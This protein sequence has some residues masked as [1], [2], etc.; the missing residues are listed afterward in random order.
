MIATTRH[1]LVL[2]LALAACGENKPMS[3]GVTLDTFPPPGEG[4]GSDDDGEGTTIPTTGDGPMETTGAPGNET[5]VEPT[6]ATTSSG[7]MSTPTTGE[8]TNT[9]VECMDPEGQ[10]MNSPCTDASGCGCESGHCAL[11]P[12]LGGWCGEC[13]EDVHC[14]NAGG[15]TLPDPFSKLGSRC[16]SGAEAGDGCQTDNACHDPQFSVCAEVF[17]VLGE[18]VV[19][20]C[21]ECFTDDDCDGNNICHPI[22]LLPRLA[23]YRRCGLPNPYQLC[24]DNSDCGDYTPFCVEQEVLKDFKLNI[25][26]DCVTDADCVAKDPEFPLCY[27]GG[28]DPGKE[29]LEGSKCYKML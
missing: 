9:P 10:S 22:E 21:S 12:G 4:G 18:T 23:G 2:A 14:P 3:T 15:C 7:N 20:G 25:C 6:N 1:V 8:T 26:G 24:D 27:L 17:D 28:W 19:K 16:E 11:V 5:S 13:T 29:Y